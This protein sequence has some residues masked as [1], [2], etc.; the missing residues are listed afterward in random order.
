MKDSQNIPSFQERQS[1]EPQLM[2]IPAGAFLMGTSD[3]QIEWLAQN[4]ELAKKWKEKGFFSREQPQHTVTLPDYHI[5]RYPITVAEYRTFIK[6]D[7]YHERRFWT[8]TGWTWLNVENRIQPDH[9]NDEKWSGDQRLPVV[10]VSWYEAY[11]YC[12]WLN[13]TTGCAYRLPTEA[14]WEKTARGIDGRQFP[15]GNQID[16]S[17]SNTRASGIE[18]TL[19][20]GEYSPAGDSPYGCVDMTGNVSEWTKT[21]FSPYPYHA[22]DG[23]NDAA[24]E[25]E[26]TTRGGSWHSLMLRARTVSRRMNDPFFTDTD[27]GFRCACSC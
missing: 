16:I 24:G 22:G 19:S 5:G 7:G 17:R 18:R 25:F 9:C 10:G 11:A 13:D 23:R 27:L 21:K 26:R 2:H 3:Q 1:F 20:V 12:Q 15:W 14:E 6:A 8:K 4:I